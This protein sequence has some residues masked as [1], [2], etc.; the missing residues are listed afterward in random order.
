MPKSLYTHQIS[1]SARH[2]ERYEFVILGVFCCIVLALLTMV[3]SPNMVSSLLG[4]F[5]FGNRVERYLHRQNTDV[6]DL[7]SVIDEHELKS[8]A[9]E[10]NPYNKVGVYL[11]ATSVANDE[12]FAKTFA[13]MEAAGADA[14]VFDVKGSKVYFD[15]TSPFAHSIQ[16]VRALYDLPEIVAKAKEHN[17]YI[18][19]RYIALKDPLIAE[20]IPAGQIRHPDTNVSAG[21]TWVD[22]SHPSILEYNYQIIRDIALANVDEINLDYIRYPTEYSQNDIGLTGEE[23]SARV[24]EFVKMARQAI[25]QHNPYVKLGISTYAILGWNFPINFEPLGQDVR[26]TGLAQYVDV[27]SPMAYPATFSVGSYYDADV[28]RDSRMHWL[29]YRT[30][31]GYAK[32]LGD[33]HAYKIRPWIQGYYASQKDVS[34]QI[35]AVYDAGACGFTMWNAKNN[36]GPFYAAYPTVERPE[37][38][39]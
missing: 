29:V 33:E 18:I 23:K 16:Q 1:K 26:G 37:R 7:N 17:L 28:H 25:D 3:Y 13:T 2:I 31:S 15:T 27:I 35:R 36:H 6:Y 39:V 14:F 38:C 5:S 4:R 24:T 19:A 30:L 34:D 22:G 9:P 11:T 12:F 32:L 20:K 10:H 8:S 21:Y